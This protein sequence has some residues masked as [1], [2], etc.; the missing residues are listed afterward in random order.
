MTTTRPD[1]R[2]GAF[3]LF[4]LASCLVHGTAGLVTWWLSP[5]LAQHLPASPGMI[6][7]DLAAP[8]PAKGVNAAPATAASVPPA[9]TAI[10]PIAA[11]A[12][13][14]PSAPAEAVRTITRPAEQPALTPGV[15][16]SGAQNRGG[17]VAPQQV[18]GTGTAEHTS[19]NAVH[20]AGAEKSTPREISFGS[21]NGPTF[22]KQVQPVFPS[23]ARR[24]G[25][26]GV[27]LLRLAINESGHLTQVELLEDPGYGF[28][29]AA[30]EAVRNSS[31]S[32]AHHNGRPVAVR[33]ILPIRFTLR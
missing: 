18:G 13:P 24:R 23:L 1:Q 2:T 5:R 19:P 28:A 14:Q 15:P 4:L 33:A 16:M 7:V 29:E 32:P 30:I 26:E 31:F 10:K 25:K 27:V 6:M 12:S 17:A 8:A 11:A 3:R 20:T 21:A 9:K 22:R